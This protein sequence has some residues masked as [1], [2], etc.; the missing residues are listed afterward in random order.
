MEVVLI[1]KRYA[2]LEN[3]PLIVGNHGRQAIIGRNL[4]E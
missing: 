1:P 3:V 4:F 2:P